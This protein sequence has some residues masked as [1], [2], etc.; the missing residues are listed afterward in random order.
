MNTKYIAC[1]NGI[2]YINNNNKKSAYA[3]IEPDTPKRIT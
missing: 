3:K 2:L 1:L